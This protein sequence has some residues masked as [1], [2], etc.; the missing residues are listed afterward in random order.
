MKKYRNKKR[1]PG[2]KQHAEDPDCFDIQSL[3][4]LALTV[5]PDINEGINGFLARVFTLLSWAEA[6]MSRKVAPND[7]RQLTGNISEISDGT[8]YWEKGG[9]LDKYSGNLGQTIGKQST[10]NQ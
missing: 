6:R 10:A 4:Q 3:P 1:S 9:G 2:S 8:D 5:V 7:S